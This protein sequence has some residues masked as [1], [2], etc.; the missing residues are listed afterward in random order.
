MELLKITTVWFCA[1]VDLLVLAGIGLIL[2]T[3]GCMG[4]CFVFVLEAVLVIQGYFHWCRSAHE[5]QRPFLFLIP[6]D[7]MTDKKEWH[8]RKS[9]TNEKGLHWNNLKLVALYCKIFFDWFFDRTG[10][11]YGRNSEF[12]ADPFISLL[13]SNINKSLLKLGWFS[14]LHYHF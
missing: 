13:C 10:E 11:V 14:Y 7:E 1:N 2:F 12:S 6:Q 9:W 4:L 3:E 5:K 8:G